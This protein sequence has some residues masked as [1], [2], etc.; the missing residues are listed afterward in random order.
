MR[1]S[2]VRAARPGLTPVCGD[3]QP[4]QVGRPCHPPACV[5][6]PPLRGQPLPRLWP[7]PAPAPPRK[8]C[9]LLPG[10]VSLCCPRLPPCWPP[11]ENRVFGLPRSRPDAQRQQLLTCALHDSVGTTIVNT[12]EN[13]K[14]LGGELTGCVG[15][16]LSPG[17]QVPGPQLVA[18]RILPENQGPWGL[19]PEGADPSAQQAGRRRGRVAP[20]SCCRAGAAAQL[21]ASGLLRTSPGLGQGSVQERGGRD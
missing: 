4:R 14:A 19:C 11:R 10:T 21:E 6:P 8:P 15:S 1:A 16:G 12:T 5:P 17:R 13:P 7:R 9:S 18:F 20:S 3:T 2:D